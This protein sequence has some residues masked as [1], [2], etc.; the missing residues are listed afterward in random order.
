MFWQ[1]CYLTEGQATQRIACM[2]KVYTGIFPQTTTHGMRF[3]LSCSRLVPKTALIDKDRII[4]GFLAAPHNVDLS[5]VCS[6]VVHA[7]DLEWKRVE[8]EIVCSVGWDK[9][10]IG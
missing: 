6:P 8:P 4:V 1:H 10:Q 2:V 7:T 3:T 5:Y 9:S